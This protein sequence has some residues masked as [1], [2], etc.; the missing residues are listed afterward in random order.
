M[1]VLQGTHHLGPHFFLPAS[2]SGVIRHLQ[3]TETTSMSPQQ[4]CP[5]H[6]KTGTIGLS[7]TFES[8]HSCSSGVNAISF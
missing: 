2:P 8:C 7:H 6:H 4:L 1:S 3:V 5:G